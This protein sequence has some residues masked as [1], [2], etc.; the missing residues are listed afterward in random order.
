MKIRVQ[1][2]VAIYLE[3]LAEQLS[4]TIPKPIHPAVLKQ[5]TRD[6]LI[7]MVCWL[8]PKK[9]TKERLAHKSD[10]WLSTMIGNDVNI[11]SYMIEQINSSITNILDYSQSEVTDF[12]QKSQNEIHYLASKPVE[13][14]DPYDNANYHALRSKTNTTKKVYAIFTSDVLAED[15]YAVTTKPS[16]FFDT[17]E[18]AEAEIDNIIKEQQF[19]REELTIHSLWQIQH[20]EY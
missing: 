12:F 13:Q 1:K 14:W 7:Q 3:F 4:Q 18:E 8:F 16:Y 11:L 19:K 6:E 20:N 9:F 10:E 5:L 15:V 17:K 2:R